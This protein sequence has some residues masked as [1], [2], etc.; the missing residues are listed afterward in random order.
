MGSTSPNPAKPASAFVVRQANLSRP[1]LD[2][3]FAWKV[4]LDFIP[5]STF[6]AMQRGPVLSD[7]AV[8]YF[9]ADIA[10]HLSVLLQHGSAVGTIQYLVTCWPARG[11]VSRSPYAN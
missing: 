6:A 5:Q 7:N 2:R 9:R 8:L 10:G 4:V 3:K 1:E 11:V